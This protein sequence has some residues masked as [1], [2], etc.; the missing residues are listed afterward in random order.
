MLF[1]QRRIYGLKGRNIDV[2]AENSSLA[3]NPHYIRSWLDLL[4]RTPRVAPFLQKNDPFIA[5]LEKVLDGCFK[6]FHLSHLVPGFLAR[7]DIGILV[8]ELSAHT[9][10]VRVQS[11]VL[12]G[13]FT[14]YDATKA[15]LNVYQ[16]CLS[17]HNTSLC[18]FCSC[19]DFRIAWS[20][21]LLYTVLINYL[22]NEY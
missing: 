2:F 5:A 17:G 7:H 11:D 16:V 19:F 22:A 4:S 13:M 14:F 9:T 3:I 20:V 1:L 10:D 18:A 12:D 8:Q 6:W 21:M 15:T